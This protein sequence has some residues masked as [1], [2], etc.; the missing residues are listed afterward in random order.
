M[1]PYQS[2]KKSFM[3]FLEEKKLCLVASSSGIDFMQ[4]LETM[5]DS[6]DQKDIG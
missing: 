1:E 3:S 5:C 2:G 4:I 6:I